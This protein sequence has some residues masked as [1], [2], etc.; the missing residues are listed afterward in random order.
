[1]STETTR[2]IFL[3]AA[4]AVA[5]IKSEAAE[6][7]KVTGIGGLFF[8][9]KDPRVLAKWYSDHL[10]VGPVPSSYGAQPWRQDAGPCAFQPFPEK[11]AYFDPAKQWMVNFRVRNLDAM[12]AQLRAAGTAVEV[13]QKVYPNGRFAHLTDPEGNPIELWEEKT[14]DAQ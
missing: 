12:V 1:M 11:T 5:A 10:G 13:D 8:R 7:E 14:R 6:V 2:R 3:G 9:A 4:G